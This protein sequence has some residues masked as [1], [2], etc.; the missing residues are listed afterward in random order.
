MGAADSP[1]GNPLMDIS[2]RATQREEF[3]RHIAMLKHAA[4]APGLP[5]TGACHWCDA[6]LPAGARF[7]DK[8]CLDGWQREQD[9]S[10]RG[11][12]RA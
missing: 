3:D 10:Q 1:Q 4:Y 6:L 2:D 12:W 9:A 8:D 11:G 5:V 7:C